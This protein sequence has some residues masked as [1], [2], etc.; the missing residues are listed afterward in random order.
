M[1]LMIDIVVLR[2][3]NI[4]FRC[5]N[6]RACWIVALV[7]GSNAR[8]TVISPSRTSTIRTLVLALFFIDGRRKR[9]FLDLIKTLMIAS[10]DP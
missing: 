10:S 1:D 5:S 4:D 7:R 8:A 2:I 9:E 6:D 3:N